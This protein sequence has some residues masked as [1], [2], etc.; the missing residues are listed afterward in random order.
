L[1]SSQLIHKLGLAHTAFYKLTHA[2]Y[3]IPPS[4]PGPT[5]VALA[6]IAVHRLWTR[7]DLQ[8]LQYLDINRKQLIENFESAHKPANFDTLN[9]GNKKTVE[10][11]TVTILGYIKSTTCLYHLLKT[12]SSVDSTVAATMTARLNA[13]F[14]K[15]AH[16]EVDKAIDQA[17]LPKDNKT[18]NTAIR[19]VFHSE[20]NRLQQQKKQKVQNK[21]TGAPPN[22]TTTKKGPKKGP[23]PHKQTKHQK[24][25]PK[26]KGPQKVKP[27]SNPPKGIPKS[28]TTQT[29]TNKA[30]TK[31]KNKNK[32][33]NT[34]TNKQTNEQRHKKQQ[35]SSKR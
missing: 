6:T 23:G 33:N 18:L 10:F 4:D 24:P 25:S 32:N 28:P 2:L 27:L 1:L 19:N 31:N 35:S 8:M 16:A 7:L 14:A 15:E 3:T 29:H 26:G 34:N 20:T 17:N 22:K 5:D 9:D 13:E 21:S 12:A 30:A 11:V